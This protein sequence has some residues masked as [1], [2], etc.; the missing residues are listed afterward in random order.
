MN[1][2]RLSVF[3]LALAAVALSLSTTQDAP[4]VL[5]GPASAAVKA[6]P[7]AEGFGTDTPGG[8]GGQVCAVTNL[9]DSGA[10]SLR[11]CVE[12][13]GPRY[14]VF[15]TGGTILLQDR[16]SVTQ[17]FITIAG[18]TAP[19]GG[20]T[21]RME[22][23]TGSDKGTMLVST[24]DV[25]I[26]YVRFRPGDGGA[27]GDSDDAMMIYEPGVHD[28]VVDHCSFSWAVDENVNTYDGSSDVTIS[29]SIIAEGLSNAGH[30]LGEHSKGLLAGGVN[31]HNVSIHH[32]LFVSNVDRN[33][34]VSGV[35]VADVR[36]NV[37]YNYGDGSGDG[38]TL[39]SSSNGQPRM[40]WVGNYYKPGPNSDPARSEFATYNG[41]T[42]ASQQ[43]YGD[44]NVR[45]TPTGILSARVGEA[46][47][48][49]GTPF[50]AAPVTTT[51]AEQAYV[52]VLAG[53]GAS[54]IRDAVDQRLV[55]E[56]RAG[57]GSFKDVPGPYP[58]LPAGGAPAD[59]DGDGMP[60]DYETSHGTNPGVADA[61]GDVNGNGYDNVEDWFNS[62]GT[63]AAPPHGMIAVNRGEARTRSTGVTLYLTA[64][65]AGAG[66]YV[67]Q[68]RFSGDGAR[69]STWV[70]YAPTASW[71][72]TAG[73][74]PRAVW[75][76]FADAV[77]NLSAPVSDAITLDMKA[78][79]VTRVRPA[80][81]KDDV[82]RDV[83]I[84]IR[85]SEA[86][87]PASIS[88]SSVVLKRK[89]S[90]KKVKAKVSYQAAGER[91]RL[92]PK[93]DLEGQTTYRARVGTAVRDLAGNALDAK[94]KA[95]AQRLTWRFTTR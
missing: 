14:V 50:A 92:N 62:T 2:R 87:A 26:R 27:A 1:V 57:T 91:I 55:A 88:R 93:G 8:R 31:A 33:P 71:R 42:G 74:G 38:I 11:A 46:V 48:Q 90:S 37:I 80:R 39:L 49:V 13:P 89:G 84:K 82:D 34:Q 23:A 24:H 19:G 28:V 44:G 64:S 41:D 51:S 75:A 61:T 22:P 83:T 9:N 18:Q 32:N 59:A 47:G 29:N 86:L 65:A 25:V 69:Y 60:D 43:W 56:V 3:A 52:D 21:L 77:G 95:G 20:I 40:N 72:L 15:R 79:R 94:P 6:F 12:T 70:P 73:N 78:P 35:S 68:M 17:P 54:R 85:A 4:H 36:N 16:I 63:V 81:G 5:L 76:Q 66:T 30:P 45:W 67:T 53:A 58:D 10:G 7:G